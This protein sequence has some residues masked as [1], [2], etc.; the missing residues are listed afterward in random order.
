MTMYARL[1]RMIQF[2]C[3]GD[4]PDDSLDQSIGFH[5]QG[6]GDESYL[7]TCPEH[8]RI[9]NELDLVPQ[10]PVMPDQRISPDVPLPRSQSTRTDRANSASGNGRTREHPDYLLPKQSSAKLASLTFQLKT[11]LFLT[12]FL[13]FRFVLGNIPQSIGT[14]RE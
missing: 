4:S 3:T 8:S 2:S 13:P 11:Q 14:C 10:M 9:Q 7:V 1:V 12:C 5:L 6:S